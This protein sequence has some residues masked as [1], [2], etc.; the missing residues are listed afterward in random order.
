M[1]IDALAFLGRHPHRSAGVDDA[2]GLT[3]LLARAGVRRA[4]VLHLDSL[5]QRDVW[6]A[7]LRYR[8]ELSS[9]CVDGVE[10][11]PLAGV[12][13]LYAAERERL[14][15]LAELGFKGFVT[16][17][18]YHGYRLRSPAAR[19]LLRVSAEVGLALVLLDLLEDPRGL[20]RAYRFRFKLRE[21]DVKAFLEWAADEGARVLLSRLEYSLVEKLSGVISELG[22]YVDASHSTIYGPVYDRVAKLIELV[23]EDRVVFSSGAPLNYPLVPLYKVLYSSI[24]EEARRRVLSEN[25]LRL[26]ESR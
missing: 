1:I 2:G 8:R 19:R 20:H 3:G 25:A 14:V 26:Y 18:S 24:N 17:P 9:A 10:L 6:R 16:S 23:G 21:G 7:N 13:P 4:Y 12:N 22:A 15:E 5:F 11:V